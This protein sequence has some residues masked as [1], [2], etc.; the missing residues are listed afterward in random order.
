[1][2]MGN[3]RKLWL[4]M[5]LTTVVLIAA[6]MQVSASGFAQKISL[7]KT[8]R[9]LKEILK[10]LRT[11]SGYDFVATDALLSKAKSVTINVKDMEFEA[12]LDGVGGQK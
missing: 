9:P 1:M 12:V 10:N 8:N 6:I 7:S 4:I 3:I 11:Q 2:P 5:R